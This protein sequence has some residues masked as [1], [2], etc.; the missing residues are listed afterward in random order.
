MHG[1]VEVLALS[2]VTSSLSEAISYFLVYR[3]EEFQRLK[4]K[5]IQSERKLEDEKQATGGSGKHRQRRIE[6]IETQL[7]S[8]RSKASS[9][10]LRNMLVVGLV[11]VAS[12]YCV[13]SWYS[14]MVVGV[15]PFEPLAMFRGLTHRGLPEDSPANACSATFVFVLGGLMFKAMLDRYLQLGL[16]KGSSLPQ[17]LTN[18]D[19]AMA[20]SKR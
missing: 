3:T 11:Q 18:P 16:P 7:S 5:V 14:G 8:A 9:I 4:T 13:N 2:L 17:W 15:L 19:D 12:I 20:A 6:G 10:Q 1:F